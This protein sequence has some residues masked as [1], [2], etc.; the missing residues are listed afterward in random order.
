LPRLGR[1]GTN[2]ANDRRAIAGEGEIR[3]KAQLVKPCETRFKK[4]H[5][6]TPSAILGLTHERAN[7]GRCRENDENGHGQAAPAIPTLG[8]NP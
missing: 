3:K 7:G 2:S 6:P 4:V 8:Q 1:G 5:L